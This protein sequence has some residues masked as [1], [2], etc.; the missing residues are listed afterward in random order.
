MN[1]PN[2]IEIDVNLSSAI[3][4]RKIFPTKSKAA[5]INGVPRSAEA[6]LALAKL[7]IANEVSRIN[8]LLW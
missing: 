8:Q 3:N 2:F 5:S 6:L 1:A 4:Y 7:N